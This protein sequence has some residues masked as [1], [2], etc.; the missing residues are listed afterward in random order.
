MP[1][2]KSSNT[3]FTNSRFLLLVA[4][5]SPF[6]G[7][8]YLKGYLHGAGFTNP[9]IEAS[10]QELI[11]QAVI[12]V[13]EICTRLFNIDIYKNM[14]TGALETGALVAIVFSGTYLI[15]LLVRNSKRKDGETN[16]IDVKMHIQAL[17]KWLFRK[18]IS[19]FKVSIATSI[20]F[21]SGFLLPYLYLIIATLCLAALLFLLLIGSII[22]NKA[23]HDLTLQDICRSQEW[24]PEET[25]R[26]GCN[27]VRL[28]QSY[29]NQTELEGWRLHSS[30]NTIFLLTN[31]GAYEIG[32][33]LTVKLFTPNQKRNKDGEGENEL[34][35]TG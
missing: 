13:G 15:C 20:G 4:I 10:P 30:S 22:G 29:N 5:Y 7:Y 1:E 27:I 33:D 34:R 17:L 12:A 8:S 11:L 3:F 31:D 24:Q 35:E 25:R 16:K 6:F 2:S 21:L 19:L 32:A 9:V 18:P 23:G 14:L 28:T 26:L